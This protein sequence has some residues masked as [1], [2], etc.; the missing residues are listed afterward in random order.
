MEILPELN[1][2]IETN[3]YDNSFEKY[4]RKLNTFDKDI[5]KKYYKNLLITIYFAFFSNNT[6]IDVFKEKMSQNN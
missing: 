6:N 3:I 4:F 5:L 2:F 1:N